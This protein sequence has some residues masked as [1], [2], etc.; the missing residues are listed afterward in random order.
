MSYM[1]YPLRSATPG[2]QIFLMYTEPA[3]SPDWA[4]F[5]DRCTPPVEGERTP[6]MKLLTKEI[7]K[8][9]P[10][11]YTNEDKPAAEVTIPVKFFGGGAC[12]WYATEYDPEQRMFFGFV[13]LGDPQNAELGYFSLDELESI[14]FPP[15]R[16]PVERDRHWD[17]KTTLQTVMDR[18]Y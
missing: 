15:F 14:R 2:H 12:T 5:D 10:A 7:L 11:L 17:T 13:T 16:L 18:R 6:T 9:L 3:I 4:W 8:K 1:M